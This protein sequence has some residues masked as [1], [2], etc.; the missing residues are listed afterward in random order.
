MC[1]PYFSNH[2]RDV[3]TFILHSIRKLPAASATTGYRHPVLGSRYK[4]GVEKGF[5]G[6]F[7][8]VFHN[9]T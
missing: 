1:R 3:A 5:S 9:G 8:T 2:L 4:N 7:I 6:S